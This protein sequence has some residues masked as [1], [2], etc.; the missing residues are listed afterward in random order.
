M[1]TPTV[2]ALLKELWQV[3]FFE[4]AKTFQDINDG[5]RK[6]GSN[7]EPDTLRKALLRASFLTR[8][9]SGKD[10]IYVQKHASVRIDV[11]R[12]ILPKELEATL[13][14]SFE[15]ELKD[16]T[17]CFG[18][19]GT[20]TAFLLRKILEKLIYITFAKHGLTDKLKDEKNDLV[21]LKAMLGRCETLKIEGKPFL[22]AKTAR[23]IN[24][25]K[26]LGDTSAHNPLMNVD[27]E[28]ILP[29]M[30]F[31][32]VAYIELSKKL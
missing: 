2:P 10:R 32:I 28:I 24:G 30:P 8:R 26:F 5:L 27:M 23:E 4:E 13:G 22:M 15:T 11:D 12:G 21:G 31:I 18:R 29:M 1:T 6:S 19:S 25:I 7:P 3:G 16:L 14:K 9:R 20:C 17:L